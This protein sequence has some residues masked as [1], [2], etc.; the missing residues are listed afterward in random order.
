M[1]GELRV[2]DIF[3]VAFLDELQYLKL[4]ESCY[5][6]SELSNFAIQIQS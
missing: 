1:L 3:C 4:M 2:A 6:K 5:L